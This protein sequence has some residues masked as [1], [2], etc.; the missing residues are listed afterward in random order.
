MEEKKL[1]SCRK[2]FIEVFI[3]STFFFIYFTG[4]KFHLAIGWD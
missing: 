2:L 1:T 3:C 4:L